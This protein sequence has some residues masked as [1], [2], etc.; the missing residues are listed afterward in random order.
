MHACVLLLFFFF[1]WD[2]NHL[3][4]K[5]FEKEIRVRKIIV[6]GALFPS[7]LSRWFWFQYFKL[8]GFSYCGY[9][10]SLKVPLTRNTIMN[11][12][13]FRNSSQKKMSKFNNGQGL[14]STLNLKYIKYTYMIPRSTEILQSFNTAKLLNLKFS[15]WASTAKCSFSCFSGSVDVLR[16]CISQTSA[17]SALSTIAHS[18]KFFIL[19][20]LLTQRVS[21]NLVLK[22]IVIRATYS[23]S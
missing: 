22:I 20:K 5:C 7:H 10:K 6:E 17:V 1:F 23:F 3:F 15:E 9:Y 2:S 11:S 19:R 21:R 12:R 18:D 16:F 14:L 4:S 8:K 13:N